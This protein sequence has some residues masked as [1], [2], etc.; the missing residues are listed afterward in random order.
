MGGS[1]I[2]AQPESTLRDDA[3]ALAPGESSVSTG[4][5]WVRPVAFA[6]LS[7]S[8]ALLGAVL[9]AYLRDHRSLEVAPG[10]PQVGLG[11]LA[12]TV[13]LMALAVVVVRPEQRHRTI[14]DLDIGQLVARV[15]ARAHPGLGGDRDLRAPGRLAR[16]A[17]AERG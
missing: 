16:D 2:A 14:P 3:E 15:A 9:F 17:R 12:G 11:L 4:R 6:V 1:P 8:L 5:S 10:S 13:A 7:V